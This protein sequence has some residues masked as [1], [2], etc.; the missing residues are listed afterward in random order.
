VR[1]G[2]WLRAG[3]CT[4]V[5]GLLL[6]LW[7]ASSHGGAAHTPLAS[8]VGWVV[9]QSTNVVDEKGVKKLGNS[10]LVREVQ[11]TVKGYPVYC[12]Y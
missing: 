10:L 4:H 5:V 2:G 8:L 7:P 3:R 6:L 1:E 12:Q 11:R 9:E